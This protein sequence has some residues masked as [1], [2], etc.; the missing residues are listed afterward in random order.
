MP[1][2]MV[3]SP[4]TAEST[5]ASIRSTYPNE[6]DSFFQPHYQ[7]IHSWQIK[8][9]LAWQNTVYLFEGDGYFQQFKQDRWMPEYGLGPDRACPTA[10]S[11]TPPTWCGG[12]RWMSGTRAGFRTS[13][14]ATATVAAASRRE[15]PSA[16]TADIIGASSSGRNSTLPISIPITGTTTTDLDKQTM[17]PFVQ[18]NW[19]FSDKWN[20]MAGLTWTHHRYE[21]GSDKLNG[22]EV[23]ESFSYLLPRL[24]VTFRPTGA[25]SFFANVSRGGR[26]PAFRDIYDPQSTWSP[27]PLDLDPEELTDYEFGG[28]Y[29]WSTGRASVNLYYLDFDNAIVWAGGLDNNGDPVTANGAVTEHRGVEVDLEW[30]PIPAVGGRLDLAWSDNRIVEFSSTISTATSSTTRGTPCR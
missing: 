22:V 12:A 25:L 17:Q 13:S 29:A 14:G 2:S 11:S 23:D 19:R 10:R 20:L 24:G 4:A 16:F 5:A 28:S 7:V 8:P 6:I 21:M 18:E 9:D 26:E 3:R 1:I 27:A 30:Q 15:L